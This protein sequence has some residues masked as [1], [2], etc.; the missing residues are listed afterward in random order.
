MNFFEM[1]ETYGMV[2]YEWDGTSFY[3]LHFRKF[4]WNLIRNLLLM[5]EKI[6]SSGYPLSKTTLIT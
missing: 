3:S 4:I 2:K 1:Q 5:E 6:R